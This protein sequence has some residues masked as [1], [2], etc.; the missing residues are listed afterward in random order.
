MALSWRSQLEPWASAWRHLVERAEGVGLVHAMDALDLLVGNYAPAD[1]ADLLAEMVSAG[2]LEPMGVCFAHPTYGHSLR[3][4][5][6]LQRIDQPGDW[7]PA[8]AHLWTYRVPVG[9]GP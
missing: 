8:E 1:V 3:A 9:T 6:G 2:E 4:F 7:C 5:R